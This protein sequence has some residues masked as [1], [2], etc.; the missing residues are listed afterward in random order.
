MALPNLHSSGPPITAEI[1]QKTVSKIGVEIPD[2]LVQDYTATLTGAKQDI[3]S[4]LA[5]DGELE[6]TNTFGDRSDLIR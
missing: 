3:E 5:M 2:H 6:F 4:V 1:L